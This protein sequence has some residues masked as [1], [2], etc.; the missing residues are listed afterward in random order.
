MELDTCC[1]MIAELMR[2]K[3]QSFPRNLA[4]LEERTGLAGSS[5]MYHLKHLEDGELIVKEEILRNEV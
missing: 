4:K 2:Q 5:I 1:K 3:G